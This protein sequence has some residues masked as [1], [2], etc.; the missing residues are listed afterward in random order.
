MRYREVRAIFSFRKNS[1]RRRYEFT[2]GTV[3][4]SR[5]LRRVMRMCRSFKNGTT[6]R[7]Y[8]PISQVPSFDSFSLQ[9]S[10]ERIRDSLE[11]TFDEYRTA[12]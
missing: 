7:S 8:L 6:S 5:L 2:R 1:F 10:S 4:L 11:E 12:V 3:A 9:L